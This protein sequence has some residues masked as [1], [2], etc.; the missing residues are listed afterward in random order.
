[1]FVSLC[2]EDE[3]EEEEDGEKETAAGDESAGDGQQVFDLQPGAVEDEF[4][5]EQ[6][7][8]TPTRERPAPPGS[9]ALSG[10]R[11][12]K[13]KVL[14]A[15]ALSLSLGHSESTVSDDYSSAFLSPSPEDDEDTGLDFD[16]D[17]IE[18][19]SDSESLPFPI[20]DLEDDMRRLGVASGPRRASGPRSGSGPA[21]VDQSGPGSLEQEDQVDSRGTRWRCFSTGDPPQESRVNMS[22]LQP[23]LRVLSHGGYY[24]DGM[25]DIIV[26]SSCYLP[27][28]SL[29]NYQHVMD[30]LFRYVV[31]TLD[32]M[33][34]ENYVMV[35]LC[36]GGQK[37]KL[38]GISWLR[39]CY[40][41]IDRR[42]RKNLKGFYV[43]HPTWYIKALI[44]I[45]KPFISSKFSR[46]LQFVDS[47]QGLSHFIP[48]EH[49]QIPDCVREYDQSLSR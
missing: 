17:A 26:F 2:P 5:S 41:T 9:L 45:I 4:V 21:A 46:K 28:S 42:L 44:T 24:G 38:P 34:S 37:D 1:M 10:S 14:L 49:V 13:K 31:G 23:F 27:E 39:E 6:K 19:P 43:V 8:S 25:N 33:V 47:L 11:P 12:K 3:E 35:Y 18:T 36:A 32:L 16:L 15:P 20:Y 48:T 7:S 30:N 29:E 22:V 40:T